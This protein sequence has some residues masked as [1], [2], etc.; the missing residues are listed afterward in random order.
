MGKTIGRHYPPEWEKQAVIWLTWPHNKDEWDK[1][2]LPKIRGFYEKLISILLDF[3]DVNLIFHTEDL[4]VKT[5]FVVSPNKKHCLRKIIIPNNDIWIRDYGPFF[6]K[7][8]VEML[9]ATSLLVDFEFNA[10][11]GK[12]PPWN[13]DNKVPIKISKYLGLEIESYPLVVEGGALEFSGDGLILTT[14]PCILNKNRNPKLNKNQIENILKSAFN[15]K[16]VIWLKRGLKGDHTDGHIDNVARFIAQR[17]IVVTSTNDKKDPDY[18]HLKE[19]IEYLKNWKHPK[20]KYK[21]EVIEL[22]MPALI[23]YKGEKLPASYTNFIFVNGGIIVP[24][25][26]CEADTKTLAIFKKLFPKRKVIGIDCSLLI[27]EGGGLH[28]MSKQQP[29]SI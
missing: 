8:D 4:L 24:T 14:E 23:K 26:N 10:W 29:V 11:G 6:M 12:Y 7:C 16:E 22:P 13:L 25:F 15:I 5:R 27:Q 2:R 20:K 1:K 21:L 19:S 28:C 18:K 3:Q 17:K 9:H